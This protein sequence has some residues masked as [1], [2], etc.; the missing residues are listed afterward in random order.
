MIQQYLILTY[1]FLIV[2]KGTVTVTHIPIHLS[3]PSI[4][5]KYSYLVQFKE[6]FSTIEYHISASRHNVIRCDFVYMEVVEGIC[7]EEMLNRSFYEV[8]K[9]GHPYSLE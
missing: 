5:Q 8:F 6:D 4:L 9:K 1:H 3:V 2:L 7:A